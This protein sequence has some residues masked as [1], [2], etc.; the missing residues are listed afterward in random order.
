MFIPLNL[1]IIVFDPSNHPYHITRTLR[2][3]P[4]VFVLGC[5][6]PMC[7]I[8]HGP[9]GKIPTENPPSDLPRLPRLRAPRQPRQP[10]FD[11][12]GV[13]LGA[14]RAEQRQQ[15]QQLT[16]RRPEQAGQVGHVAFSG[17]G[18]ERMGLQWNMWIL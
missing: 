12:G 4:S 6:A 17:D 15:L 11:A 9:L 16:T 14:A 3:S 7:S 8:N 13:G 18:D 2:S 1:I 5:R 10:H